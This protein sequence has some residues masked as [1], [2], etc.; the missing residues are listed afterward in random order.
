[1]IL[2][3]N[4]VT[5]HLNPHE[6][7]QQKIRQKIGKLETHLQHFP[8]DAVHL[9]VH[10][11]RHPKREDFTASLTLRLPSNILHTRKVAVDPIAA[12]D[13]SVRALLREL[14][15]LKSDLR[16]EESW[17]RKGRRG[18]LRELKPLRFAEEPHPTGPQSLSETLAVMIQRYH[19]H[20]LYFVQRQL[21][22]DQLDDNVPKDAV[23]ALV[24]VDE[25]A[26]QALAGPQK[27]PEDFSYRFWLFDLAK[28]ELRRRYRLLRS[29]GRQNVPLDETTLV[30]DEAEIAQGYDAEKPLD[31]IEEKI[32]PHVAQLADLL[33][34]TYAERPDAVA[35]EHDLIDY[36]H[37]ISAAWPEMERAVFDLHF[38]QGFDEAE[39]AMLEKVD[40]AEARK[41]IANVQARLREAL[42]EA[43][44]RWVERKVKSLV[45]AKG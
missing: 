16:R 43:A 44:G 6:Q 23:D 19:G 42:V 35:T 20:L 9:L 38:L 41:L 31:I 32:E 29:Q 24:V 10:I 13:H 12:F 27:K 26:R 5:K 39:F 1:M 30:P 40:R 3:W 14:S 2:T 8:P 15:S 17:K 45:P 11:E 28:R 36:L 34:D 22:R 25:V 7:L 4:L 33:P 18:L 21:W 37:Q